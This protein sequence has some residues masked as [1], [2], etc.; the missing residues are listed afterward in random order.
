MEDIASWTEDIESFQKKNL[1]LEDLLLV[2]P[3]IVPMDHIK[4]H[5]DSHEDHLIKYIMYYTYLYDNK[6]SMFTEYVF[7]FLW[8]INNCLGETIKR[9]TSSGAHC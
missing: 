7:V 6:R 3:T 2:W 8:S 1:S 5:Q 9:L 4:R